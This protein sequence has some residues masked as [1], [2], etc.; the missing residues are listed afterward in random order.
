MNE[1]KDALE[2][3]A[4]AL[5]EHETIEGKHVYEILEHGEI[6]SPILKRESSDEAIQELD[7]DESVSPQNESKDDDAGLA[8]EEAPAASP[9]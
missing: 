5:L 7:S 9:A 2:V 1:H 4:Q 8:G 6:R 3:C